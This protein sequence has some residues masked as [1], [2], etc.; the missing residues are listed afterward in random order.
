MGGD[1]VSADNISKMQDRGV[2]M[3]GPVADLA[4]MVN[5][6]AQQRGV[7]EAYLREAFRYDSEQDLYRCPEGGDARN[8]LRTVRPSKLE[9]SDD[10][11]R[12]RRCS[13]TRRIDP[14]KPARGL[15]CRISGLRGRGVG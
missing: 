3:I 8:P 15:T 14:S 11:A 10:G 2:E 1:Y 4:V 13:Y 5:K 9:T 6:Q 7:S 12:S